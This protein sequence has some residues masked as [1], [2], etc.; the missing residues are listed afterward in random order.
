MRA[1]A[2]NRYQFRLNDMSF[3]HMSNI[4]KFEIGRFS[5]V[6]VDVFPLGNTDDEQT[7]THIKN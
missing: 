1:Y 6:P 2:C 4:G 5:K 7:M 3:N